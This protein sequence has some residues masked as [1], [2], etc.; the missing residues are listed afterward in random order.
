MC[1]TFPV[2]LAPAQP[3]RPE[4][5]VWAPST[6]LCGGEGRPGGSHGCPGTRDLACPGR[7]CLLQRP[8]RLRTEP[9][10]RPRSWMGT[11]DT[12][13]GLSPARPLLT[14]GSHQALPPLLHRS[15]CGDTPLESARARTRPRIPIGW[16]GQG[17]GR[18]RSLLSV[19]PR[20]V[21]LRTLEGPRFGSPSCSAG[22]TGLATGCRARGARPPQNS[23]DRCE[24]R[25]PA[26]PSGPRRRGVAPG[27]CRPRVDA[28][29]LSVRDGRATRAALVAGPGSVR[30]GRR[31]RPASPPHLSPA[32]PRSARA[33]RHAARDPGGA[34]AAWAAPTPCTTRRLP[35]ASVRAPLHAGP[36]SR[37]GR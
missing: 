15:C 1:P 10:V 20:E 11:Q 6:S 23:R 17:R 25:G 2:R 5:C 34:W 37:H 9:G 36:V 28:R 12:L 30:P 29:T 13:E 33:P 4:L 21:Q 35:A 24:L 31:P 27:P 22:P 7:R 19:R 18:G 8:R 32:S 3:R 16:P 14:S 26:A